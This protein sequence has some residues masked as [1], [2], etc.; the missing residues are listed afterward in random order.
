MGV[1]QQEMECKTTQAVKTLPTLIN[2]KRIPGAKAP[3]IPYHEEKY[4]CLTMLFN[5][6]SNYDIHRI[7]TLQFLNMLV[8]D[9]SSLI[10]V[11]EQEQSL[12]TADAIQSGLC[13]LKLEYHRG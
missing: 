6:N 12:Q 13:F 3:R 4:H 11:A 5:A 1:L 8:I 7:L 9:Y 10:N 2:G